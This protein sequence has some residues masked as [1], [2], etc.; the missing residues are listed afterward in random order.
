MFKPLLKV[1]PSLSG[2]MKI[3]CFCE[4]YSQNENNS[5]EY[6][7]IIQKARLNG[8]TNILYDNNL[9]LNLKN[10]SFEYDV[11]KFYNYY[12]DVFYSTCF[13]YSKINIPVL[14]EDKILDDSNQAFLYGCKRIS[15]L[16]Y[17][18]PLAFF[19]PIYIDN[20]KDLEGVYFKIKCEFKKNN[21][22][23][24]KYLNIY[25]DNH[26]EDNYLGEYINRY[27]S[28]I[29]DK[30][31]YLSNS[32]KNIYYGINLLYG[33]FLKV[34]DNIS[35]IIYSKY[36]T[37]NDF[38]A[39]INNGF[40]RN[41]IM[42]KQILALN[43]CFDPENLL[44]EYEKRLYLGSQINI[45]GEW[46]KNETLLEFYTFSDNYNFLYD[47]ILNIDIFGNVNYLYTG[48]NIM[49]IDYP[50]FNESQLTNYK[51]VNTINKNYNRWKL[52]YSDDEHPYYINANFAF[53]DNQDSLYMYKEFPLIYNSIS[54]ICDSTT[55]NNLQS[56]YTLQ[57]DFK[58]RFN[59][60]N[61]LINNKEKYNEFYNKN[62]I[63]TFYN[64]WPED[65]NIDNIKNDSTYF[66][67][68]NDDNKIYYKGILYDLNKLYKENK[69]IP[70]IDKFALFIK[71][72]FS[73]ISSDE[74]STYYKTIKNYYEI[75]DKIAYSY[76][77]KGED[78]NITDIDFYNLINY[79]SSYIFN[80]VIKKVNQDNIEQLSNYIIKS[81]NKYNLYY[82][83]NDIY[84][85]NHLKNGNNSIFDK[86]TG[87]IIEDYRLLELH[88]KENIFN[89]IFKEII[90]LYSLNEKYNDSGL[91][92]R[93][94]KLL[95]L[96][97]LYWA[98][99]LLYFSI[100]PNP[101]IYNLFE[102]FNLLNS[103]SISK[104]NL[105][106]KTKFVKVSEFN[107]FIT[108]NNLSAD[109][110]NIIKY[111]YCNG[112][113][114]YDLNIIYTIPC[115]RIKND[116]NC[117]Y[118]E[119]Y[120]KEDDNVIYVDPYNLEYLYNQYIDKDFPSNIIIQ[121]SDNK[122]YY[123]KFLN[124]NHI[125]LYINKIYKYP[126]HNITDIL[127]TIYIKFNVFNN[128]IIDSTN[129]SNFNNKIHIHNKYI[130]ITNF[131]INN[132]NDILK[133]IDYNK[134]GYFLFNNLY[135]TYINTLSN[136][137]IENIETIKKYHI[138]HFDICFCKPTIKLNKELYNLIMSLNN[139]SEVYKDLYLY[140]LENP[141]DIKY[142]VN[143]QS[144][145]YEGYDTTTWEPNYDED[146][147][148]EIINNINENK[149][150]SYICLTPYFNDV[151]E[152]EQAFT[153]I[154]SDYFLNNILEVKLGEYS[155]YRFKSPNI[156]T[157]FIYN[158]SSD[159]NIDNENINNIQLFSELTYDNQF[160]LSEN[161]SYSN[162]NIQTINNINYGY[163]I[164]S[165]YFDNTCHTLNI[166]NDLY[167]T[168]NC[169]DYIDQYS[170]N[171]IAS[172]TTYLYKIYPN[173]LPY[174]KNSNI[175]S[176]ILD[177]INTIII[178]NNYKITNHYRQYKDN[179]Q[180]IL[181]Y[182]NNSN[183]NHIELIRYFDY[184]TPYI[185]KT[186]KLYTYNLYYK[187][188]NEYIEHD[189][190][191]N[192]KITSYIY[193][194]SP[195]LSFIYDYPGISYFNYNNDYLITQY[196]PVEYK[197]FN[198]NMFF[199]L[200]KKITISEIKDNNG[201][202]FN[203]ELEVAN[204][205]KTDIAFKEFSKKIKSLSLILNNESDERILFLYNKY[206]VVFTPFKTINENGKQYQYTLTIKY[207]LL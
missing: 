130:P 56:K 104:V 207:T 127:N 26:N 63:T 15:Y 160:D 134:N 40:K 59:E 195:R 122:R 21:L 106:L 2:N 152:E 115:F 111:F 92:F 88:S 131:G 153:K 4:G 45:S 114:D 174:I 191:I 72:N 90:S 175:I 186:D 103:I 87:E 58:D 38:D 37:I 146:I 51:F 10:N 159:N 64:L 141:Q 133:Y 41:R 3:T 164:I 142:E 148:N 77:S 154:Y 169:I 161:N 203:T 140:H 24:E 71:P 192:K 105:F 86:Y 7:C 150:Q 116:L 98:K 32:Y 66:G 165:T 147:S 79:N 196:V 48:K 82:D 179:N 182:Y 55:N 200:P 198:D 19:A 201:E 75:N 109:L 6:D 42:M 46:Y 9:D 47:N 57:F 84:I 93:E 151:Y 194:E 119:D 80:N 132:I 118:G 123:Y 8:I 107:N 85:Y 81:Y 33:G 22:T 113:Y 188:T 17:N 199:N 202:P 34:E 54:T 16:K 99:N 31:V 158:Y 28:K 43:F 73:Y 184:I 190:S 108:T 167:K 204:F 67:D 189:L 177:K 78:N 1:I 205:E 11:T 61:V 25:I 65:N 102:N 50:A 129:S 178:P 176:F 128:Y 171:D 156:D 101:A 62:H 94:K 95:E 172:N 143:Y 139:N 69:D 14:E 162:I 52:I 185:Y 121:N 124:I 70:K 157:L 173:I 183:I 74:Y 39:L 83:L 96:E 136:S 53:S 30:V 193:P 144:F 100:Y 18:N 168:I 181:Y 49:N 137:N 91:F 110:T 29:D 180:L 187:N 135:F 126:N 27:V 155:Y 36:L 149:N 120:T 5:N 112:L 12:S 35:E 60:S 138:Y 13:N 97:D 166:K 68:V 76:I 125:L 206:K 145:E 20:V 23:L 163:Y 44:S 197:Y 170:I 89:K 117:Y